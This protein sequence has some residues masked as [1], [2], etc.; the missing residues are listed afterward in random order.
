[1]TKK[2]LKVTWNSKQ[3]PEVFNTNVRQGMKEAL[4]RYAKSEGIKVVDIIDTKLMGDQTLRKHLKQVRSESNDRETTPVISK[5]S[6]EEHRKS[7][8]AA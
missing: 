3:R 6:E 8:R 2:W 4:R 7:S 1:M 5:G